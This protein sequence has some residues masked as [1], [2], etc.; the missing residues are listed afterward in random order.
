[1]R[2]KYKNIYVQQRK[3]AGETEQASK[4]RRE[5]SRNKLKESVAS[6]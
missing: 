5:R 3:E 4:D 2:A 6:G 1:V